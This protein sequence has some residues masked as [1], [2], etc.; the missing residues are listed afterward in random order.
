MHRSLALLLAVLAIGAVTVALGQGRSQGQ[1]EAWDTDE[2]VTLDGV[3]TE[4]ERPY[5]TLQSGQTSYV[6]HLGPPWFW[7]KSGFE[8]DSGD[9]VSIHGQISRDGD[10]LHLYPH[11]IVRGGETQHRLL[12]HRR[13]N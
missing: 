12:L 8:V 7:D 11:S 2:F 9:E 1:G 6:V 3:L 4:V 5:A 13:G 10:E